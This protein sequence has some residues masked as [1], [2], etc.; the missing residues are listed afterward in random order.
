MLDQYYE[1]EDTLEDFINER[2]QIMS[3]NLV[4]NNENVD[5][6]N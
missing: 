1:N 3:D 4:L 6:N 2:N 5:L